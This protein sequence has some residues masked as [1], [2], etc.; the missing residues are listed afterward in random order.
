MCLE[1][2]RQTHF[3]VPISRKQEDVTT[4][5]SSGVFRNWLMQK[6]TI[7]WQTTRLEAEDKVVSRICYVKR[8]CAIM[9]MS[10]ISL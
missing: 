8:F 4:Y 3:A 1:K 5:E 6:R 9:R 7:A 10:V 2:V